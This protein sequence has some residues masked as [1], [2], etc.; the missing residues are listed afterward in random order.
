MEFETQCVTLGYGTITHGHAVFLGMCIEASWLSS[1]GKL[2]IAIVHYLFALQN[3]LDMSIEIVDTIH[4]NIMFEA[5]SL[6][7]KMQCDTLKLT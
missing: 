3:K 7:K 4:A 5:I 2:P 6:D 1:Q